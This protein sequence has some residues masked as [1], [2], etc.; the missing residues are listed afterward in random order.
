MTK[1]TAKS[2]LPTVQVR[3]NG[4]K[5]Q[6]EADSCST[7]NI[8]DEERFGLLQEALKKKLV[9][10]RANTKL[11]AYGQEKPIP[12]AG[13]FKADVESINTGK[14]VVA[15]IVVAKGK[16]KSRPLLSLDT[17]VKP[18]VL[19]ITDT[20]PCSGDEITNIV[21]DIPIGAKDKKN[22]P[23]ID[24]VPCPT[25]GRLVSSYNNVFT[26]IGKHKK[27]KAKFI[28]DES[29]PA[30]A[31]KQRKVPY[32]LSVKAKIEEKRLKDLG[33]IEEVPDDQPI[34][35]C[36]NPVIAPKPRNPDEIRYCSDMRVPNTAIKRPIT[37]VPTVSDIR[38]RLEGAKVFSVLD[39]NEGYHQIE[40]DK[41]SRHLTTFHG[42][43][44]KIRYTRLNFGTFSAQDIFD[45]AMDDT[46]DDLNEVLHIRDDFIV[47]GRSNKEH[48]EALES[49]LQRFRECGL[50][51]NPKKC[52]FRIPELEFFGLTFSGEGVKPSPT[53]VQALK[54]MSPPKNV[55]EVRSLLGMAQYSA[56]FFPGFSEITAPLRFLTHKN[57][58]WKWT[59]R[60]Q[61]SVEALQNA[62]SS[63]AVI[64]YYE[65]GRETKLKVDAGPNGLGLILLQKKEENQWQPVECASRSLTETEKCYLQL[66][67]EALAIRWACERCYVYLIGSTFVV[68]TDHKPLLP[69]FNNPNSFP[70]LR[71]ERWLLYL[72]QFDFKLVYCPG[73]DNAADYLSRHAIPITS[74]ERKKASQD[75]G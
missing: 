30:M 49:L 19:T 26:G 51:F 6:V 60:E 61:N 15:N 25:T 41:E 50:T 55:A 59:S 33:I 23:S 22:P 7:A 52:K 68:E 70:P 74:T 34:T 75:V 18:G 39:M 37:E 72:Q 4:I 14:K 8:I 56:Q 62:L 21:E 1:T 54:Q 17:S 63:D 13:S 20:A 36:T 45:K 67:K 29:V 42:T 58:D 12:L 9:L 5:G 57:A 69:L 53:K 27:I 73:K 47:Y 43:Q 2:S 48:D 10:K 38:F 16:T 71:I 66:E 44:Q 11:Y 35:W 3:I 32:N 24:A 40:L 28:V 65:I 46:I 64:G 31:H